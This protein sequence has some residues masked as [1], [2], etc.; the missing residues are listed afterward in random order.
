[1]RHRVFFSIT[2]LL[3]AIV[4]QVVLS[5]RLEPAT[6]PTVPTATQGVSTDQALR[7]EDR[8]RI[9]AF[10]NS[11]TAGLGVPREQSYPALLEQ[12][13]ES[14]GYQYRVINAGVSGD[15]TAGGLRRV[16]WILK[17]LPTLVILEL[18]A[19]DGLRG[20]S[21]E[22][23]KANLEAIIR[24][25]KEARVTIILAGMKLPPNYGETYTKG[26]EA[27]YADLARRYGLVLIP[28]FLDGVAANPALNQSDGI[29]PTGEGYKRIVETVFTKIEPLL[30][31]PLPRHESP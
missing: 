18:G 28:F 7:N 8:P 5:G 16:P 21:L 17:S 27:L 22:Q 9:V 25:L 10:G 2:G 11:L 19:N 1:M 6:N 13:L 20:L 4:H 14:M 15:T 3:L 29:H 24:L 26:F 30:S 12:R 31:K 23:T